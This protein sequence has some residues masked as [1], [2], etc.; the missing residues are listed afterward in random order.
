M[1][2]VQPR[3]GKED[4]ISSFAVFDHFFWVYLPPVCREG[5][6]SSTEDCE[7]LTAVFMYNFA[8]AQHLA[9]TSKTLQ[10][11]AHLYEITARLVDV[12]TPTESVQQL[13]LALA[14]NMAAMA[15]ETYNFSDFAKF[16][17]TTGILLMRVDGFY[18]VFFAANLAACA[19]PQ[20]RPAAA[21]WEKHTRPVSTF[22]FL[23]NSFKLYAFQLFRQVAVS[24]RLAVP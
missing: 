22:F 7:F 14:N 11:A 17:H 12:L 16:R 23:N 24:K 3:Q 5:V 18:P 15:L 9:Y 1:K 20:D 13:A 4:P 10:H 21:A 2:A 19:S 6:I 8:L